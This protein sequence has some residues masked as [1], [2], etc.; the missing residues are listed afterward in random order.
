MK[1]HHTTFILGINI[2]CVSLSF[3]KL[4]TMPRTSGPSLAKKPWEEVPGWQRAVS[5]RKGGASA[6][7]S[8]FYI[9][10][11]DTGQHYY[12]SKMFG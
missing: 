6:G 1:N 12:Q 5:E 2:R 11:Q 10:L 3:T 7:N 4:L 9:K 8:I